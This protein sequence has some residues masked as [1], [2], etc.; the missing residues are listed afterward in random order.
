M[1]SIQPDWWYVEMHHVEVNNALHPHDPHNKQEEGVYYRPCWSHRENVSRINVCPHRGWLKSVQPWYYQHRLL[2]G[3]VWE[4]MKRCVKRRGKEDVKVLAGQLHYVNE[5][6]GKMWMVLITMS[7]YLL[8]ARHW[9]HPNIVLVHWLHGLV[10][11]RQ[12]DD[13][14]VGLTTS[15]QSSRLLYNHKKRER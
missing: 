7:T 15:K 5:V 12:C 2:R 11:N 3:C 1:A 4:R 6:E 8:D 10:T 13:G 14:F 9:N